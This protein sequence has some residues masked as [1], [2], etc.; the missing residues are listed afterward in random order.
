MYTPLRQGE[1]KLLVLRVVGAAVMA[2]G[3]NATLLF[4]AGGLRRLAD[5][6]STAP[7]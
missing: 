2:E 3:L 4:L 7:S 1:M 6:V 5:V